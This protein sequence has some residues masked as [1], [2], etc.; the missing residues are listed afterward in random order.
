MDEARISGLIQHANVVSVIDV[1]EDDQGPFLIMDFVDGLCLADVV[2]KLSRGG[3]VLPLDV[4]LRIAADTAR[5]L[6]AAHDVRGVDGS[7][8][9]VVSPR[10]AATQLRFEEPDHRSDLFALGV[11]LFEMLAGRRLYENREGFDGPRR[12]LHEPPPDIGEER[13][14]LPP[15][16]A[17]LLFDLL[18]KTPDDCPAEAATVVARD[19]G[20]PRRRIAVA[21]IYDQSVRGRT[22]VCPSRA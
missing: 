7:P 14:G 5:G 12:V 18:A 19:R 13:A 21:G 2:D 8:L 4:C 16:V 6:A 1:G 10:G 11:A 17:E 20:G 3:R 9:R 22:G 15:A